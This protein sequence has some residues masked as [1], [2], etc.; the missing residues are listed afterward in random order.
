AV[1]LANQWQA[2]LVTISVMEG[3]QAPDMVLNW[4]YGAEDDNERILRQQLREDMSGADLP[5]TIRVAKGEAA[6]SI[7]E[8]ADNDNCDIIVTGM[9][10]SEPFG[11][12]ILG[13]TVE[14]L[15][16]QT[17]LP[18]LVVRKRPH[19][20]YHRVVVASDFSRASCLA[21]RTALK[22]F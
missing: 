9:A 1:Q 12:F 20:A 11:R 13:T 2:E 6:G 7:V 10:R 21:L 17:S 8:T 19:G 18:L 5:V 3:L 4:A 22:L 14:K 15:V 16:R